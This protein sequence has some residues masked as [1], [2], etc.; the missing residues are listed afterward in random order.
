M[1]L[2]HSVI[3]DAWT[4]ADFG[5]ALDLEIAAQAIAFNP[6]VST[7]FGTDKVKAHFPLWKKDPEVAWVPELG[8]IP[9]DDGETDEVTVIP[10][11]IGAISR[12]SAEAAEDSDPAIAEQVAKGLARQIAEGIDKAF[13]GNTVT[14]GPSGLL[15]TDYTAIDTGA[16][17]TNLDSFLAAVFAAENVGA[18]LTAWAMHPTVAEAVSKI[19][20]AASDNRTLLSYDNRG[21]TIVGLPVIVSRHIDST[22][23]AWGISASRNRTVLRKGTTVDR[24][25]DTGF[26]NDAIDIR[27]LS[28]VGFGFLQEAANVRLYN[29]P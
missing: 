4:P 17:F 18:Q 26:A 28:R 22:T 16:M 5:A 27:G 12:V 23:L 10:S 14:N 29:V 6:S 25:K 1:A 19:K 13:F 21:L 3:A 8:T 15:S 2:Q 24:S 11:K 20:V 7:V 9:Q